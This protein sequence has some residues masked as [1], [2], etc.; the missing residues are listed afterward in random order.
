MK[1]AASVI[2]LS[3]LALIGT[4][5]ARAADNKADPAQYTVA[6]HVSGSAYA[7][8]IPNNSNLQFE[9]IT[10]TIDGKHY[11]LQGPTS[12]A[13]VFT[14]GNGLLNPGDYHAKLT[15]DKHN[16]SYESLE[17]FEILF[18][19]GTTRKFNVVAQSE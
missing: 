14:H 17:Q 15:E 6:V 13:K 2:V 10:A 1:L 9:V 18:P 4:L 5:A 8:T 16:T 11:Q 7:Y 3:G 12:S 19:D